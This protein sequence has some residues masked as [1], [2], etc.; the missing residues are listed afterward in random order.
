VGIGKPAKYR[1]KKVVFDGIK[2]ASAREC[3]RYV[4]LKALANS[5]KITN[6]VLQP[7][8]W[9]R[10][11]NN[12]IKIRSERYPNGRRASYTADF[13]FIDDLGKKHVEDVKGMDT[14]VSRLRRAIV[15][16]QYGIRVE[17]V[18]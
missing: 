5:G 16:A 1:N 17:I 9:L 15:E 8:Y 10:C 14:N 4:E 11:G 18:R 7:K 6:L 13:E 12:D 3:E 2:F